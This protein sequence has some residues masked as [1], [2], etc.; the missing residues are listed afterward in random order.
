MTV[1][2]NLGTLQIVH[3]SKFNL[4]RLRP[5]HTVPRQ[6]V[7]DLRPENMEEECKEDRHEDRNE[8]ATKGE[9]VSV[10]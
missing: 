10:I 4:L 3:F 2:T 5:E 7:S 8:K 9:V 6:N 1:T